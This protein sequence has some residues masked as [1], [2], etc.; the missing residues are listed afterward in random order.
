MS[1]A[2]VTKEVQKA[3]LAATGTATDEYC[4]DWTLCIGVDTAWI[5]QKVANMSA[6]ALSFQPIIQTARVRTSKPNASASLD[7]ARNAVGETCTGALDIHTATEGQMY[8]RLGVSHKI[9]SGTTPLQG[10]T[11]RSR[12]ST[13]SAASSPAPGRGTSRPRPPPTCASSPSPDGCPTP[14]PRRS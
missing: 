12:R 13:T 3:L 8:F 9:N 7:V 11:T 1:C 4:T 6:S 2:K 14:K 5:V 10:P